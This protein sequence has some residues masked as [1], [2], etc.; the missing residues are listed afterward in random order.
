MNNADLFKQT[1]SI[2]AEEFWSFDEK[3]MLDWL[4]ADVLDTNI[5]DTISRQAAI[6]A[7]ERSKDKTPTGYIPE[8]YN[9]IIQNDIDKIKSLP[10]VQPERKAPISYK[11]KLSLDCGFCRQHECGDTLYGYSD[12]DGGIGFDYIRDIRFCPI[13]GRKLYSDK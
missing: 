5:G 10:S 4:N 8:F 11:E 12:W 6:D 7:L 9:T 1:F 3:R 13:C 2:Y